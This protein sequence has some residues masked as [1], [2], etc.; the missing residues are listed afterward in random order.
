MKQP[1]F[2]KFFM[3]MLFGATMLLAQT[4]YA[5]TKKETTIRNLE[6]LEAASIQKSD[7]ATL[8]KLWAKDYII[9]N[10]YGYIVTIPQVLHF[11][12]LGQIDYSYYERD[13]ER[14]TFSVNLAISMGKEVVKPQNKT[15]NAGKTIVMRYTHVWVN[16]NGVWKL[17]VRQASEV[18]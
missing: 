7:T 17:T 1:N 9:N 2:I 14:V 4:T 12:R 11:I 13:V 8:L 10:P 16:K 18:N 6:A 3:V 5:Q 15:P